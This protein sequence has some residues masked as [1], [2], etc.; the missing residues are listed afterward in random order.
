MSAANKEAS[1]PLTKGF[2]VPRWYRC[3]D[4]GAEGVKL[5]HRR[6]YQTVHH[7]QKLQCRNC[8][9]EDV[10]V[11]VPAVPKNPF[12]NHVLIPEGGVEWWRDL[13]EDS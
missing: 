1:I 8:A 3:Q 13:P 11:L 6:I 2:P 5:W 12:W 4:C 7:L 10:S 9:G